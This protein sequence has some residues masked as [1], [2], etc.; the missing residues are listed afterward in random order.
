MKHKKL[1]FATRYVLIF[2]LLMLFANALLGGVILYQSDSAMTSLIHKNMLDVVETAAALMD[3]DVLGALTEAD[4]DGEVFRD[5]EEKLLVFQNHADIRFIYAVKQADEN[6]YVFTVDPDPVDPG[7]FGE[8]IVVTDAL[9]KAGKGKAA[10]DD[11]PA[12]DRWG[13][14]YSAYCPVFDT[15]GNVAGIIGIDFDA[16]WYAAQI[17]HYSITITIITLLS[18]LLSGVVVFI[19]T[20]NVKRRF[21]ELDLEMSKLSASMNQMM[22]DVGAMS[23]KTET[24]EPSTDE[25][26]KLA[27]KIRTVQKDMDFYERLQKDQYY[28]DPITGIPNLNYIKRFSDE[29]LSRLR[30]SG[31]VPAIVYFDIRS[32]LSY[33]T[34]YGYS[35]G[36]DLLRLTARTLHEAFPDAL[37]GRGEGDHFIVIG[38]YDDDIARKAETV[39]DTIRKGAFG[40]TTGI[41][42]ALVKMDPDMSAVEGI[43]RARNTMKKIGDDLNIVCRLYTP[44]DEDHVNDR[45]IV[46]NF[47]EALRNGWIR[48]FYQPILRTRTEKM[49]VLEAL[50]RWIDPQHGAISPGQFIPVL[51]KYHLLHKLDLYMLEQICREFRT[52][53]EADLPLIP[54]SINFSAQDFDY[55]NIP[56][57]LNR[58]LEKYGVSRDRIIVEIT[59]QDLAQATGHFKDQLQKIHRYGYRLWLDDFG[60]GY[61]SLNVFSQ[62]HVD[63][64]KFDMELVRHLDDN[65]GANRIIMRS[66]TEMCRQMGVHTLAEGIETEDQYQFLLDIDCEMVQ[67]FYFF[68]PEPVETAIENI[69][70]LGPSLSHETQEERSEMGIRWI[71]KGRT[72]GVAHHSGVSGSQES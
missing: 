60:S 70:R 28:N 38:A 68:R 65:H 24:S 49:T 14:F 71:K 72:D 66:I 21:A 16:D 57:A 58:L 52:R 6:K 40:R 54:V 59:E 37:V 63:R 67:G 13:N 36:D 69:R 9:I 43:E 23:S 41:Q 2:G 12:A 7:A 50:A 64:I 5:I 51:S 30:A 53:E 22:A 35:R 34:E 33:N 42:C 56:E 55:V 3:G 19:I 62:Y 29:K 27:G 17:N 8:E 45:F 31:T 46:Q 39:N 61:S 47:E 1:S 18:V 25:L 44:E 11:K 4:V 26:E 32:M 48:V 20:H 10:V 15:S